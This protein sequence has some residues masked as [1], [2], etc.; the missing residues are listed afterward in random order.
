MTTP[1]QERS[2][3]QLPATVNLK[4]QPVATETTSKAP[5]TG[6]TPGKIRTFLLDHERLILV[7]I[8]AIV[9][10]VS[11]GKI[12]DIIAQHD[13][14]N[15]QQA[16]VVTAAQEKTNAQQ[17]AQ[18]AADEAQR[19]ALQAKLEAMNAQLV[20]AN[21]QLATALATRQKTDATLPVTD[22]AARWNMLVPLATPTVTTSGLAVS[23]GGA[24]ATVQA[25]EQVPVLKQELTNETQLKQNDDQLLTA[26]ATSLVDF[27]HRVDGLNLLIA[28]KDKQCTAQM[29]VVKAEAAKSKRRWGKIGFVLGFISGAFAMHAL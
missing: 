1:V 14:A 2:V 15:L 12:A 24:V 9:I 29:A 28:D 16:K 17:A 8:A 11:Y 25:L 22:L 7:V 4:E 20:S 18:V 19:Q 27:G 21:T 3:D 5:I 26:D 13:N 10:W 23:Q 6:S